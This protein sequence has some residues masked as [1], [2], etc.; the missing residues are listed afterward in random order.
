GRG[1]TPASSPPRVAD[2]R[3]RQREPKMKTPMR[4]RYPDAEACM[5]VDGVVFLIVTVGETGDVLD[6][7]LERITRNR[8]LD[9]AAMDAARETR[10]T[11]EI[12]NGKPV[13]SRARIPVEFVL[14][15]VPSESCQ[16]VNVALVDAQGAAQLTP[17][18]AG[19]PLRAKI[20][21]Y[22]PTPLDL[23]LVLR[24]ADAQ[25][26]AVVHE[27]RRRLERPARVE[28]SSIDFVTPEPLATGMYWLEVRV[29]G[30]PRGST[31]VEVR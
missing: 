28:F 2:P 22:V 9:R 24:R 10:W 14:P 23:D 13:V 25:G 18:P 11:P 26:G 19:Q 7:Q 31:P 1:G 5:R 30:E 3:L 17:P 21:L 20:G 8:M 16:R 12:F 29:D 4:V 15:E 6:V 27:Q